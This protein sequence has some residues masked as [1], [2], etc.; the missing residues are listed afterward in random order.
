[1]KQD[2]KK[3]LYIIGGIFV[4]LLLMGIITIDSITQKI[5]E[6]LPGPNV[7][8]PQ[9]CFEQ[10]KLSKG[11]DAAGIFCKCMGKHYGAKLETVYSSTPYFPPGQPTNIIDAPFV[12][13]VDYCDDEKAW[14]YFCNLIPQC[15]DAG[16][17]P[18]LNDIVIVNITHIMM[19]TCQIYGN[20][21]NADT[22]IC[23]CTNPDYVPL[24]NGNCRKKN[25]IELNNCESLCTNTS[26]IWDNKNNI[27][28]C[29]RYWD[30]ETDNG[31]QM[32]AYPI[33]KMIND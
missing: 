23:T 12:E 24:G 20:T 29:S 33:T 16:P 3:I 10:A 2:T 1:M 19:R 11:G 22:N 4:F 26:G 25:C 27:C 7:K 30:W 6:F 31:C 17:G 8:D 14:L 9:Y 28:N 13:S 5:E 21:W 32:R 18:I 15:G